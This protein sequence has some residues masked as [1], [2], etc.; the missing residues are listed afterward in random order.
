MQL[1]F[2]FRFTRDSEEVLFAFCFPY[3]YDDCNE[4]LERCED[5]VC[6]VWA[7]VLLEQRCVILLIV[8]LSGGALG[9]HAVVYYFEQ[10]AMICMVSRL[11]LYFPPVPT[12]RPE[13][14]EWRCRPC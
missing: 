3:S 12:F 13:E 1:Q 7:C 9:S 4:D 5:Q 11:D 6:I 10:N 14:M 2:Q 8:H